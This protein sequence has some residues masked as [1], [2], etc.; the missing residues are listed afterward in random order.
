MEHIGNLEIPGSCDFA[1]RGGCTSGLRKAELVYGRSFQ[2]QRSVKCHLAFRYGGN[3]RYAS[4]KCVPRLRPRIH[5][6][7][8]ETRT[9]RSKADKTDEIPME[10]AGAY[11]A[12]GK[13]KLLYTRDCSICTIIMTGRRIEGR[14]SHLKK[15]CGHASLRCA[16]REHAELEYV[17]GIG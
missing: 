3:S 12:L 6:H 5:R 17:L 11:K 8:F 1:D 16:R 2:S 9:C 10:P 4:S 15:L 13:D 14:R 7:I